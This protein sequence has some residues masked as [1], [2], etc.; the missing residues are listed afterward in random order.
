MPTDNYVM[1]NSPEDSKPDKPRTP[2]SI[3]TPKFKRGLK[4]FIT[5]T[6]REMKKVVWPTKKETTRLTF[7]VLSL[8]IIIACGLSLMGWIDDT[9]VQMITK[10]HV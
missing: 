10:G 4:G 8:C 1:S 3:A 7:V 2:A 5:E 9:A 6:R